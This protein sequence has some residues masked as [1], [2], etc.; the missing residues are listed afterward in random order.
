MSARKRL[1][2]RV[3]VVTGVS[4][5]IGIGFA[6]ATRL[7]QAGADVF[8]QSWAPFDAAQ[9][10]GADPAGM[11]TLLAEVRAHVTRIEHLAA[12]FSE[13]HAPAR[14]IAAAHAAFGRLD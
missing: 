6:I 3:A 11:E 12:D 10:W 9:P 13:P 4:R 7:A 2:G 5:R 14:L 8:I 1:A